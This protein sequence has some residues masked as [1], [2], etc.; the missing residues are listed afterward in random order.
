MIEDESVIY[1]R[2]RY[3]SDTQNTENEVDQ[4]DVNDDFFKS[5]F[6]RRQA[7]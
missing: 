6:L 3:T 1:A 7:N 5:S 4:N 2:S